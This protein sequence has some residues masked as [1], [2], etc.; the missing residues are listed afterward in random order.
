[1]FDLEEFIEFLYKYEGIIDD[2][3]EQKTLYANIGW[4]NCLINYAI[5]PNDTDVAEMQE[6]ERAI[7]ESY[8]A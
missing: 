5:V 3:E 1:M 6:F 7:K 2:F 8:D 4:V